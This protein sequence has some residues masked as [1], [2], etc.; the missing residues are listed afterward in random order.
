MLWDSCYQHKLCWS[1]HIFLYPKYERH[2]TYCISD[3]HDRC[4]R[5]M[6][7]NHWW[8]L[9]RITGEFPAQRPATRSFDVFY[10]LRL[11]EWLSKQSWCW[12]FETPSR[13]LWRHCN[14]HLP[15]PA[16]V[17]FFMSIKCQRN[18]KVRNIWHGEQYRIGRWHCRR[19]R[20]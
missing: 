20:N 4:W 14:D 9:N 12:W 3:S 18:M 10:D 15:I 6:F 1:M 19:V 8:L 5:G 17:G 16:I 13:P 7:I 2:Q 11:N